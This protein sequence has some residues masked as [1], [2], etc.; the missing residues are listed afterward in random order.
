MPYLVSG[1]SGTGEDIA[2]ANMFRERKRVFIDLLK[3]DVPALAD[4]FEVD[5]FDNERATYL[6]LAKADGTHLGSMR[7]LPSDAPNILGSIFPELCEDGAPDD[8]R[9]WEIS[10]FC[11][12]RG[13]P[14]AERR[15]IRNRLITVAVQFA[16]DHDIRGYCCV[17]DI[18]WLS[19]ILSFG[20]RCIPL[21][22]PRQ[23]GCGMTGALLIEISDDTP[24]RM[25]SAG[26]WMPVGGDGTDGICP[27]IPKES[28]HAVH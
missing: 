11:L 9:I 21:G 10:R 15:I 23:L 27:P 4:S 26:V 13:L 19:Q 20:W 1:L 25:A 6:V 22:L 2:L 3:W 17:A 8:P 7:L 14:A 28:G 12:S 16:L 18:G 5:E 24:A